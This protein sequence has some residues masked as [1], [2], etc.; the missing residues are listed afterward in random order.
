MSAKHSC[1]EREREREREKERAR[2]FMLY[3]FS[4]P[5]GRTP[6]FQLFFTLNFKF[7]KR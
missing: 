2:T 7:V 5:I 6:P 3:M 4:I 1:R